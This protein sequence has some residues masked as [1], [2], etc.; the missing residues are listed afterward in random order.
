MGCL[1][2]VPLWAEGG[3][4]FK[5]GTRGGPNGTDEQFVYPPY[6]ATVDKLIIALERLST[7]SLYIL[8]TYPWVS[9]YNV[10]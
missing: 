3:L 8:D 6:S 7:F 1:T 2:A 10:W 9:S 5:P 4:R